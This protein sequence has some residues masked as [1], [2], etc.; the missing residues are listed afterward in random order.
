M[1]LADRLRVQRRVARDP[2]PA[3]EVRTPDYGPTRPQTWGTTVDGEKFQLDGQPPPATSGGWGDM[4]W[5]R[6]GR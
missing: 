1:R 2:Q 5:L 4:S 3:A 6:P